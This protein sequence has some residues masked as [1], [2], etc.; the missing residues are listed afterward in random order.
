METYTFVKIRQKND[1][2]K[3]CWLFRPKSIEQVVEHWYKYPK[4]VISDGMQ[5]LLKKKYRG[6]FTND[7]E[8][9]VEIRQNCFQENLIEAALKVENEA[10]QTR[11]N[12]FL[13]EEEIYLTCGLQVTIIDERFSEIVITVEKEKLTFPDEEKP[14]MDD[15]RYLKWQGG[16]HTYAKIGK[17]DVIDSDGNMKW[18]T[19]SEAENAARWFI[20]KYW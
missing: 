7:F 5:K 8:T 1:Y 15:V 18:N 17:L 20:E 10:Y 11:L 19:Q 9:A 4:S 3:T 16:L 6:H 14:T 2:N 13:R 12:C